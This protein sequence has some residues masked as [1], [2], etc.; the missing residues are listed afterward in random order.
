MRIHLLAI[1][2]RM[3]GWVSA[4]YQ[5]YAQRLPHECRL[6]LIE[7]APAPRTK[8]TDLARAVREEGE[9]ML[10]LIPKDAHVIA[11]DVRGT[12][13]STEQL[14]AQLNG[15]LQNGQ[16]VALLIGGP[17]GLAPTLHDKAALRLAF[18]ALT[19]PHQLARIMLLEQVYRAITIRLYWNNQ[20]T[21][22]SL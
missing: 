9:R 8:G 3:P 20:P 15:W 11:L 10:D 7:I 4:G 22:G 6:H 19:W 18:G 13:Y 5:D 12:Q 1:G 14:S 2:T 16:D 21:I 17:D